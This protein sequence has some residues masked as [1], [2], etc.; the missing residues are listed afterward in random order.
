SAIRAARKPRAGVGHR[1]A[2]PAARPARRPHP[3]R[4]RGP[5]RRRDGQPAR[6]HG[7]AQTRALAGPYADAIER[8]DADLLVSMLTRDATWTMPPECER[9]RGTAAMREF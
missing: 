5:V 9:I 7:A 1:A 2:A 4:R 8:G 3:A 6:H